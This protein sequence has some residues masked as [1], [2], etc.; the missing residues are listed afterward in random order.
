MCGCMDIWMLWFFVPLKEL[1]NENK[2]QDMIRNNHAWYHK[3][4]PPLHYSRF[5][6]RFNISLLS[7]FFCQLKAIKTHMTEL[8][9]RIHCNVHDS[10]SNIHNSF[11]N[12]YDYFSILKN[13][14][15]L[16]KYLGT[17]EIHDYISIFINDISIFLVHFSISVNHFQYS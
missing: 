17:L 9:F 5:N 14:W 7:S 4:T 10:F 12:I 3:Q 15:I 16:K 13:K 2:W 6:N 1:P 8:H 11:F